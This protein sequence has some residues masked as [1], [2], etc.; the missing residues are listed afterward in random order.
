MKCERKE[1]GSPLHPRVR[2][3]VPDPQDKRSRSLPWSAPQSIIHHPLSFIQGPTTQPNGRH[4]HLRPS[5][6]TEYG[7]L[8]LSSLGP[9]QFISSR[10]QHRECC[11]P[12]KTQTPLS[13]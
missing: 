10:G 13:A 6:D 12:M 1:D 9:L 2:A 5:L 3:D 11:E 7:D 4:A 8:L